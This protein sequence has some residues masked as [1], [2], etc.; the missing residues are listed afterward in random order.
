MGASIINSTRGCSSLAH[1]DSCFG[2]RLS[3]RYNYFKSLNESLPT[4]S[5]KFALVSFIQAGALCMGV[6]NSFPLL[7]RAQ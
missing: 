7:V 1:I 6:T 3:N 4:F 2:Q 5:H